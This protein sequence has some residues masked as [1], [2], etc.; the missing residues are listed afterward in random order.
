MVK[1]S[2]RGTRPLSGT[3]RIGGAKNAALPIMAAV[4]LTEGPNKLRGVPNLTDVRVLSQILE[5][6]GVRVERKGKDALH[7]D[8][9]S[10]HNSTAP[11]ELVSKMRASICV[12]GPLLAK[13]GRGAVPMPGGCV[14]GPR[15]IDL[16]LK[17]LEALGARVHMEHG[18]VVV[19]ARRLKGTRIDLRG[20]F[21]STV[22]GT[23]NVMMA[24]TLA[25][26]TTVIDH[27]ACEPEIQDLAHYLNACGAKVAGVGTNTL[28]IEGVRRLHGA[29]YKIIPDRIEAGT[30]AVAAAITGG[31][32]TLQNVCP[33]HM[34][35]VTDLM[36][37]VGVRVAGEGNTLRVSAHG[38]L[39]ATD[40]HT[41]PYPGVPTDMQP[42]LTAMLALAE[43]ESV[44]TERV[45]PD[46]FTHVPELNR[47][48]ARITREGNRALVRG[49]R[50]LTGAPVTAPDLR[51]GAALVV[52]GLAAAGETVLHGGEQIDRGYERIE[53][54]LRALGADVVRQ[55][56][57]S[58]GPS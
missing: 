10:E 4:L 40:F 19:S 16:H 41:L 22:L 11:Y 5:V 39:K 54:K 32:V 26:G 52:A 38:P 50:C 42:A 44:V 2:I 35:A 6:L 23:A 8:V 37:R 53:E 13:R 58:A 34:C 17:G 55:E 46:R 25:E 48:G 12:L 49:V 21:G 33:E 1:F 47:L 14:I 24:A 51:A 20:P 31:S 15:P 30:F 3:V 27:A 56:E 43:G 57:D 9:L 7:L 28:L 45:H 18:N 29:D 36:G